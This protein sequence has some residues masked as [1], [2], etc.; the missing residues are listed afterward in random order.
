VE[1]AEMLYRLASMSWMNLIDGVRSPSEQALAEAGDDAGLQCG[2]HNTLSWVAFYLGDLVEAS[3][4]ARESAEW[5]SRADDPA[6]RADALATL[7][8]IEFLEGRPDPAL[9]SRAVDLQDLSMEQASWTESAVYTTPRSIQGLEHMWS[10]R[11]QDARAVFEHEIAVYELHAMYTLRQEVLC[12]LAELECRAGRWQLAARY[13]SEAMDIIQESGQTATQSHVV[14]FNQAWAAALLGNV[15]EARNMAAT[16]LRLAEANDDRFNAAWNHAVLGFLDLSLSDF[17]RA[18]VNLEPAARWLERLGSV[19]PAVIPCV[20]D[21]VEALV[22]LGHL[23][24]AERLLDRLEAQV[25]ARDRPW[26]SGAAARGRALIAAATGDLGAGARLSEL[27]IDFLERASQPFETARSWLVCGQIRRRAKQKRLARDALERA[28]D[29][30]TELGARLWIERV[31]AELGRIGGRRSSPFELT[32]TEA[33][34]ATLVARG[35]TNREAA[36]ALF[37]SAGTVQANLKR[38]Y[39]KLEVRSRTELA[40]RLGRSVER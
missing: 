18:R 4:R 30:F 36:D 23:S 37:L 26:A 6:M 20:P 16:G 7:A 34:I 3:K 14:L 15:D 22:G 29:L 31:A 19:E 39:Q 5:A 11:L 24:E 21:L 32:E 2:I 35:Y 40:A 27:S 38:I 17:E 1:R 8:F 13:G 33:S 10:G 9:M 25:A 12:Y 28:R